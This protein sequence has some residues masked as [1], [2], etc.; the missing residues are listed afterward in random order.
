MIR[1]KMMR[2]LIKGHIV[3]LIL[4]QFYLVKYVF[5]KYKK[6]IIVMIAKKYFL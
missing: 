4:N 5:N 6:N 1:L 2:I 3:A